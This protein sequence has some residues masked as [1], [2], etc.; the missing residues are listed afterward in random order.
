MEP[1]VKPTKRLLAC[2]LAVVLLAGC[3]ERNA[4]QEY[5][6]ILDREMSGD[7]PA[8]LTKQ[9]KDLI[10]RYGE[11]ETASRA[12]ERLIALRDRVQEQQ[13]REELKAAL[14][15]KQN[16]LGADWQRAEQQRKTEQAQRE[17][18]LQFDIRKMLQQLKDEMET[19]QADLAARLDRKIKEAL[20]NQPAPTTQV[21]GTGGTAVKWGM[22]GTSQQPAYMRNP[23]P[24]YPREARERGWEGTT[25][26]R[27]EVLADGTAG[28]IE[29]AKSSGHNVLDDASV[30]TV[31]HWKF[32]PARSGET[33]IRS[34]VEVPITFR[35]Q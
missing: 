1:T 24:T 30:D 17:M 22:G 33:A 10:S 13:A 20:T 3:S 18:Q 29:I 34:V 11:T 4:Q 26:L 5:A 6:S 14:E 15:A 23:P 19:S 31:R 25:V 2:V 7:D 16:Q 35:L 21:E 12:K 27:V 32:S 28:K 9:Y 8:T